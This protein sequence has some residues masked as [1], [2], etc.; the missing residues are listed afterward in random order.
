[1]KYVEINGKEVVIANVNGKF[2]ALD[3]R[4]DHMNAVLSMGN[5][6][7]NIIRC[8]FHGAKFD[9]TSGKKVS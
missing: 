7:G 1:M 2:Y 5:V 9:V 6:T 3:D 8:H 4:C